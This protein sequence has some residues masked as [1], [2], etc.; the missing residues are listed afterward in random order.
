MTHVLLT[1]AVTALSNHH[2]Y[3]IIHFAVNILHL[4]P[5]TA[6]WNCHVTKL[7]NTLWKRSEQNQQPLL[8][9]KFPVLHTC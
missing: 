1:H 3:P 7:L 2:Y 6:Q 4:T 8:L 9:Q 5:D